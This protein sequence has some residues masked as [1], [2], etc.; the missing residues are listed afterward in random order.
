MIKLGHVSAARRCQL[1]ILLLLLLVL[2]VLL[3]LVLLSRS[4]PVSAN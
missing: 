3:V 2:L 4:E 1:A